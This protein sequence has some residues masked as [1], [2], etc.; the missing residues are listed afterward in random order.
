MYSD[1]QKMFLLCKRDV[2]PVGTDRIYLLQGKKK[3]K[4]ERKNKGV[5]GFVCD[6]IKFTWSSWDTVCSLFAHPGEANPGF[7]VTWS[8]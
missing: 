7:H 2:Q 3:K 4:K 1:A 6:T 5:T 8:D